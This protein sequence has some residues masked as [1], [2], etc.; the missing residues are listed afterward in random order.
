MHD[1]MRY[2]EKVDVDVAKLLASRDSL[3][4]NTYST[5]RVALPIR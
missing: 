4:S 2:V 5:V 1:E 3:S